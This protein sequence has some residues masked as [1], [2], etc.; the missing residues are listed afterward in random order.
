MRLSIKRAILIAGCENA[1]VPKTAEKQEKERKREGVAVALR[2][3]R[4][5]LGWSSCCYP[6]LPCRISLCSTLVWTTR[7]IGEAPFNARV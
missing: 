4:V 2:H 7:R 5:V 3:R 6:R 1:Y